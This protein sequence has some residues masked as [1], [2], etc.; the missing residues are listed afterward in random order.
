MTVESRASAYVANMPPAV[1][2]SHG[3]DATFA[4]ALALCHGF[5]LSSAQARP[6]MQEFNAR[7]EPPWSE[8]E[9][10]HKLDSA[11]KVTRHSQPRGYLLGERASGP[12]PSSP[13]G[14]R[15]LSREALD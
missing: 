10:E 15:N 2:G 1:S 8:K 4:V 5:A 11:G 3:H 9:L 13:A 7:C 6:I 12:S 14:G